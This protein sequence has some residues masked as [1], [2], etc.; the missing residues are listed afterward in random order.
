[1]D[2]HLF[3]LLLVPLLG[4]VVAVLLIKHQRLARILVVFCA[5]I[6]AIYTIWL[7]ARV[8]ETGR[9]VTQAANVLA[10]YGI[11]LVADML[12]VLIIV[13]ASIFVLVALLL[14]Y[15]APASKQEPFLFY[16]LLL[17]VLL[18]M[19]G[20]SLAGDLFSLYVWQEALSIAALGLLTLD[21]QHR[22]HANG[23][24]YLLPAL[25]ASASFLIGCSLMYELIGT[26]NMARL[27]NRL[28]FLARPGM[29]TVLASLFLIGCGTRAAI[30]PLFLWLPAST[31]H[32]SAA[33]MVIVGGG[34][35]STGMYMLYRLFSLIYQPDLLIL[36]PL[37]LQIA[38]L[39]MIFGVLGAL[40]QT[41][42]RR[43][44]SFLL[45]SQLG[46]ML[47]GLGLAS[48][49]GL[50]AGMLCMI[51]SMLAM[52]LMFCIGGIVETITN[53]RDIRRMGSL[54]WREPVLTTL[55]FLA[56][57]ALLGMPPLGSFFARLALLHTAIVQQSY[58]TAGIAALASLL[59]LLP[60]L[61]IQ[62]EVFWKRLPT[63]VPPP[64]R[65]TLRQIIPAV[66]LLGIIMLLALEVAP[67]VDYTT[68][69]AQ[70]AF[71][72]SGYVRDVLPPTEIWR[73][74]GE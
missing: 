52:A 48:E 74:P 61:T 69:A 25:L 35:T 36:S 58:L 71:D 42:L 1:M 30:F 16:P 24:R 49:A 57:L 68:T 31:Y 54:S 3:I 26:L 15:V 73:I 55:W 29:I 5:A 22:Q 28:A 65:V 33:T 9:Q 23:I 66:L 17:L 13:L 44:L 45:I 2:N 20:V 6:H 10:P 62:H 46:Y 41:N 12:S 21:H 63:D 56:L 51:H 14:N 59:L 43:M 72:T 67:V 11:S 64:R 34:I 7:L 19:N 39:T 53:T 50:A 8:I 47:M 37:L 4:A 60:L 18:G 27:G 40:I 70:Q 38:S 32:A